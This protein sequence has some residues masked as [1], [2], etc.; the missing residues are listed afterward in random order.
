MSRHALLATILLSAASVLTPTGVHNAAAADPTE[1]EIYEAA[2]A[3]RLTDAEKMIGQ[4]LQ[5][6]PDSGRAHFVAAEV[7]AR[8]GALERARQEL[9]TAQSLAPGLS[10]EK[11]QAIQELQQQLAVS[12]MRVERRSS[13][14]W[15]FLSLIVGIVVVWM[16]VRRRNT[17]AYGYGAGPA[18]MGGP[19]PMPNV[20]PP[21]PPP[22]GG[23]YGYGAAPG[24]GLMGNIASGL[25]VGAGVAAGEELVRHVFDSNGNSVIPNA[26]AAEY[27]EPSQQNADM[28]GS[29]FGNVDP[30]SSWDDNNGGGWDGGGGGDSGGDWT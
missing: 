5:E 6:H 1:H 9:A 19:A 17:M 26:G 14:P 20:V 30:S 8:A 24:S 25:A 12:P 18:P 3:G 15:G 2:S 4:V 10:F 27:V 21:Y 11:P 7:Y 28:G 23:G 29:D 22:Y 16:L 13:F